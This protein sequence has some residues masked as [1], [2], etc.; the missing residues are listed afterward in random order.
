MSRN[1]EP[2]KTVHT[3]HITNIHNVENNPVLRRQPMKQ[4]RH[5]RDKARMTQIDL[6]VRAGIQPGLLCRYEKGV[7][8]NQVNARKL[9]EALN[10]PVHDVFPDFD[11]LRNY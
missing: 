11:D 8:P 2:T 9:A 5:A 1:A 4:L 7:R 3:G 10:M 6:A